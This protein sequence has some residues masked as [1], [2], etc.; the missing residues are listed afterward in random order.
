MKLPYQNIIVVTAII[1]LS[2]LLVNISHAQIEAKKILAFGDSLMSGY[3]IPLRD[4]FPS[5]LEKKL[6][7]SGYDV[8]VINVGVSGDTTAGGVTFLDWVLS[9][10]KPDCV[11][12][13]LG[14]NDMLRAVPPEVTEKN[15]RK[16]MEML[17]DRKIPV[18]LAGMKATPN[19]GESFV[20]AY[21][22]MYQ[23]IAK[24]YDAVYYPFFLDGIVERREYL[25][26]DG[27]HPNAT[28]ISVVVEKIYPFVEQLLKRN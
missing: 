5:Q 20:K 14:A 11:I 8:F 25:L 13:E 26:D 19:L 22:R 7:R 18:L 24:E 15:L 6:K 3:G 2:V 16:M 27:L 28:G 21:D 4:S 23:E 17:K 9:Q 12:L 1:L 10:H